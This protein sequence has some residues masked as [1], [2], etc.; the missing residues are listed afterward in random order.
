MIDG[1]RELDEED[2]AVKGNRRRELWKRMCY[3]L[4]RRRGGDKYEKASYGILCGDVESV[5]TTL[6]LVGCC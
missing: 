3:A 1:A 4:A 5:S 2:L 6:D